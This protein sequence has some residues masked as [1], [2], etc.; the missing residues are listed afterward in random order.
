M[1]SL[2]MKFSVIATLVV[3]SLVA[4]A[5]APPDKRRKSPK[6]TPAPAPAVISPANS[7]EAFQLIVERNIFNPNRV[8]RTKGTD[9]K[10]PKTD[11]IS[12]VGTMKYDQKVMAFFDSPDSAFRKTASVGDSVGDFKVQKIATDRVELERDSKPLTLKV[13]EQLR[14]PEGGDWT[15]RSAPTV[16]PSAATTLTPASAQPVEIPADASDVLKRL[17]KKREQQLTK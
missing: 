17:L 13:S 1:K 3:V 7:F 8:G 9:E 14:R 15:V 16:A 5:E 10:P 2:P 11:E 4:A 12:L 6:G